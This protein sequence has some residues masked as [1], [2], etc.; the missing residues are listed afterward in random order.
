MKKIMNQP[1]DVLA[2]MIRG[3]VQANESTIEQV[4]NTFVVKQKELAKQVSLIS[5]GGSGHEPAHAGFVG[6]G[7]LQAAVCGQVFTSP[8]PDQIYEGIKSVNT[9]NGVVLIVKN[10]S[11]DIMNFEMA[12]ELAEL[13][14]IEVGTVVVDDDI[15]VEDSTFTQGK[16]GVAG[17]VFVHKILGAAAKQGCSIE[18]LV[19]L[20]NQVVRQL[21]TISVALSGATV[22]EVGS[23]GFTLTETD[24]EFGVGIHG[25]PGYARET[26]CSSNEIAQKMIE[27]LKKAF[28]WENGEK[29]AVMVN[30]LGGTPLMEQYIFY[31]DVRKHLDRELDVVFSK[32]GNFMTAIDMAGISLTLLKLEPEWVAYLTEPV[33]HTAW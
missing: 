32:V 18:E 15:A 11:G 16:R 12:K 8:T 3:I 13:D 23:P 5:G 29:F 28:S 27:K 7:M 10:Y 19:S 6:E 21:K 17:T 33:A 22:P 1:T 31:Q 20:G 25:E 14:G 24:I 4:P 9:G 26:M 2:E 30:G